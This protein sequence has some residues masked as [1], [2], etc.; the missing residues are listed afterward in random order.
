MTQITDMFSQEKISKQ[1][2]DIGGTFI[3]SRNTRHLV[4]FIIVCPKHCWF[5]IGV[6]LHRFC[7]RARF[8]ES[9]VK[10]TKIKP[11]TFDYNAFR[12]YKDSL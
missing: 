2:S 10:I 8:R 9:M 7:S 4:A 11:A 6:S 1:V 3:N 5:C 12:D